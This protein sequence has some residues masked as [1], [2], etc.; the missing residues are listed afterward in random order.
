CAR[1]AYGNGFDY[2]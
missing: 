2:W 1:D